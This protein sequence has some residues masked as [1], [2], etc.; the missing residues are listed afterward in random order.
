M[1][2]LLRIFWII[3]PLSDSETPVVIW[4]RLTCCSKVHTKDWRWWSCLW[5]SK[6]LKQFTSKHQVRWFC[7]LKSHLKTHFYHSSLCKCS[8]FLNLFLNIYTHNVFY[9]TV[10]HTHTHSW[11]TETQL[12]FRCEVKLTFNLQSYLW[13]ADPMTRL[14]Y[15]TVSG[16]IRTADS[17]GPA[18][19]DPPSHSHP[20]W[21]PAGEHFNT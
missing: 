20:T 6:T 2:W 12:L 21:P 3:S 8:H 11:L 19:P 7:S 18:A 14:L 4:L 17:T 10:L 13:T 1:V 15:R 9:L 5:C 16:P